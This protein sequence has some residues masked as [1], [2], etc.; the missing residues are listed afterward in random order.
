MCCQELPLFVI[1]FC[2]YLKL[3]IKVSKV[4]ILRIN[5]ANFEKAPDGGRWYTKI[6]IQAL[7]DTYIQYLKRSR[8]H[9]VVPLSEFDGLY[10]GLWPLFDA[11][12]YF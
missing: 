5:L 9:Q 4:M 3:G 7:L 11:E 2:F 1:I 10:H 8:Q 6:W 12:K